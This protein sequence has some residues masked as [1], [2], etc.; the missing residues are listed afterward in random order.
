MDVRNEPESVTGL[1]LA[2][3]EGDADAFDALFAKVYDELRR[4]ARVVRSGHA[5]ETVNTTALVH[6]AYLHLLPSADLTWQDRTHFFRV[7]ARAMRQVLVHA[8]RRRNAEKRGGGLHSVTLNEEVLATPLPLDEVLSLDA[9]LAELETL[10]PRQVQVVE[11]RYFA[12]LTVEETAEALGV[13]TATVKRD[14]RAARAWL[15]QALRS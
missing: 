6:E 9:A 4:I 12:G 13:A 10:D 2:A 1:L 8:I 5:N 3:R 15:T 7:A 11:C 14:W